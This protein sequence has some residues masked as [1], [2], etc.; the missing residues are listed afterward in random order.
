MVSPSPHSLLNEASLLAVE[1]AAP[2]KKMP[3]GMDRLTLTFAIDYSLT[4]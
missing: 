4:D 2:F 3:A 1:R